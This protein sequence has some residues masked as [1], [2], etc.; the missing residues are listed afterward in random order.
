MN[1]FV[2][3][4]SA[5]DADKVSWWKI[6]LVLLAFLIFLF[7][8][9]GLIYLCVK[10]T[11]EAQGKKID[12]L[13]AATICSGV[14][15]DKKTFKKVAKY[16]SR[17]YF[18]KK[19]WPAVLILLIC[20]IVYVSW[21]ASTNDWLFL[22]SYTEE[23]FPKLVPNPNDEGFFG[24]KWILT[25]WPTWDTSKVVWT[26]FSSALLGARHYITFFLWILFVVGFCYYFIVCQAFV[27]RYIRI[28]KICKQGFT[29]DLITIMQEANKMPAVNLN[30]Q[31][32]IK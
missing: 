11:M 25:Q 30:L 12:N 23:F 8:L 29:K 5:L 20:G 7:L 9:F 32:D 27:S 3:L 24:I 22:T 10:K 4:A 13:M 16:K 1:K 6:L 21:A 15:N 14:I 2:F 19:S 26:N 31:A 28:R 18:M 17:V